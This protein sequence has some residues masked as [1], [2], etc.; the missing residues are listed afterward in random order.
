MVKSLFAFFG[1]SPKGTSLLM[2]PKS[3]NLPRGSDKE[4]ASL[5]A[6]DAIS[7]SLLAPLPIIVSKVD[8]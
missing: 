4:L 5:P 8:A 6:L 1:L 2:Y 7:E 3:L